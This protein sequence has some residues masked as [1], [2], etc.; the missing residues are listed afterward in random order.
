MRHLRHGERPCDA[1]K[2]FNTAHQVAYQD[3][4][5]RAAGVPTRSPF[6]RLAGEERDRVARELTARYVAGA[7][8]AELAASLGCSV[9]FATGLLAEAGV[10]KRTR[11]EATAL[12]YARK[13]DAAADSA[14]ESAV[15]E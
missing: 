1:C 5:R 14:T 2:A 11:A 9:Q 13:R 10:K 6:Y 3:Q 8:L 7:T 12:W 4:R 15:A